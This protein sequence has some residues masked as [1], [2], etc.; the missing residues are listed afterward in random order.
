MKIIIAVIF[1]TILT[2]FALFFASDYI[3]VS[4]TSGLSLASSLIIDNF[5]LLIGICILAAASLTFYLVSR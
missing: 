1:G 4:N 5:Q 3:S 2:V